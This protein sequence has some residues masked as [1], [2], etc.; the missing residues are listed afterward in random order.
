MPTIRNNRFEKN[1]IAV[2]RIIFML[3]DVKSMTTRIVFSGRGAK[4]YE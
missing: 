1:L 3:S 2:F 4:G